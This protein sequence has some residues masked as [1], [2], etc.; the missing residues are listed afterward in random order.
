MMFNIGYMTVRRNGWIKITLRK[1]IVSIL[2]YHM[3]LH[4]RVTKTAVIKNIDVCFKNM[5][6]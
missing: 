6:S 5:F 3:S 4:I 2:I 1:I